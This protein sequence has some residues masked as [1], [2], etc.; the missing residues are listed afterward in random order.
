MK[1]TPDNLPPDNPSPGILSPMFDRAAARYDRLNS[2]M[3]LGQDAA[4]RRALAAA[5]GRGD[6]VLDLCC[7]S[8]RSSVEA[9]RRTS[10]VVVGVDVSPEMLARG[11]A[12]ATAQG[13][14]FAPVRGDAF[15]LPFRD[16]AF[17]VITIAWG[18]RNLVPEPTALAEM[19]RVLNQGG[20]LLVLDSP[21]P[22]PGAVGAAHRA[23][24]RWVVPALGRL[25]PDPA[26]YHYLSQ[27]ILRFGRLA[28]VARR[29]EVAG[30]VCDSA[31]RLT[32]GA[33]ALWSARVTGPSAPPTGQAA[34]DRA[35]SGHSAR[36]E[37]SVA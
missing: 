29:I 22:E 17:D 25:S 27:S 1:P 31:R 2:L 19:R 12:Y 7:G 24:V 32:L 30:F 16:G 13:V 20:R 35:T 11:F 5:V 9:A 10:R 4:W 37:A 23:Y 28:E 21:S 33:A 26:A 8:A 18:L 15:R 36:Q 14:R 6:R 3:S 34:T